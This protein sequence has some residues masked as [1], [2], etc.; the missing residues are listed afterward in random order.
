VASTLIGSFAYLSRFIMTVLLL[1]ARP[2]RLLKSNR[3]ADRR[4]ARA[5][6]LA[7]LVAD[8]QERTHGL[9]AGGI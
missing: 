7:A 2:G 9:R 8:R 3:T 6:Y 1:W 4:Q 5:Q